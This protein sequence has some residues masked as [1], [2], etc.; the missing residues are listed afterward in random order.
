MTASA[1]S[2]GGEVTFSV[3]DPAAKVNF[4]LPTH[5]TNGVEQINLYNGN[6]ASLT[7]LGSSN[8]ANNPNTGS[9]ANE[10]SALTLGNA[11]G[12]VAPVRN[13]YVATLDGGSLKEALDYHAD[14]LQMMVDAKI[15]AGGVTVSSPEEI[16]QVARSVIASTKTKGTKA[17]LNS[18]GTAVI[19]SVDEKGDAYCG[20][21]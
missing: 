4:I 13:A 14:Q 18:A 12:Y 9:A 6:L 3:W 1:T 16:A 19:C 20:E 17:T 7:I 5:T 15:L 21:E 2:A 8:F 11:L 10:W